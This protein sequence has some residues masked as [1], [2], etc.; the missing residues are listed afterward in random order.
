MDPGCPAA[1]IHLLQSM[2][3]HEAPPESQSTW[4][5]DSSGACKSS[6]T[7]LH[8]FWLYIN[9]SSVF[10]TSPSYL[11]PCMRRF[12]GI[13]PTYAIH[14]DLPAPCWRCTCLRML[15]QEISPPWPGL[16]IGQFWGG[17]RALSGQH[18]ETYMAPASCVS[19]LCRGTHG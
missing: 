14:P 9:L 10:S 19:C 7:L 6:S 15:S 5:S 16:G 17:G 12:W 13:T 1:L 2:R 18:A 8:L 3:S 11:M 4:A